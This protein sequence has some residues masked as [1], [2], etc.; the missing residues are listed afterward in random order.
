ML[1]PH[2]CVLVQ[3]IANPEWEMSVAWNRSSRKSSN[4]RSTSGK[5][6]TEV[7]RNDSSKNRKRLRQGYLPQTSNGEEL[8]FHKLF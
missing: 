7:E 2:Q 8:K 3:I 5:P 6:E 1:F 4:R